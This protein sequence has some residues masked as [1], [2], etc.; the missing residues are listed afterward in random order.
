MCCFCRLCQ[1]SKDRLELNPA[2]VICLI[3]AD[4][5]GDEKVW[6]RTDGMRFHFISNLFAVRTNHLI[7][8]CQMAVCVVHVHPR[9]SPPIQETAD[10]VVSVHR[11]LLRTHVTVIGWIGVQKDPAQ[12]F[13]AIDPRVCC[14]IECKNRFAA[15][16]DSNIR[17]RPAVNYPPQHTDPERRDT[18]YICN[19]CANRIDRLSMV[20]EIEFVLIGDVNCDVQKAKG[21]EQEHELEDESTSSSIKEK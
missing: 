13:T 3:N 2:L 10:G 14:A 11:S 17:M 9:P 18:G 7:L 21:E 8:R 6:Q 19:R 5:R 16:H 12:K 4:A 1:S 20:F 15:T